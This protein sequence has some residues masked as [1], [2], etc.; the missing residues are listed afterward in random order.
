MYTVVNKRVIT[1]NTSMVTGRDCIGVAGGDRCNHVLDVGTPIK[2]RECHPDK[3]KD[4]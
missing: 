3:N 4:V 1:L 2:V